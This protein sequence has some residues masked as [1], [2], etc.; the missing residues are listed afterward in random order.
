MIGADRRDRTVVQDALRQCHSDADRKRTEMR[1]IYEL[2]TRD[3]L[4]LNIDFSFDV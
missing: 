4:G 2:G 1:L 3:P